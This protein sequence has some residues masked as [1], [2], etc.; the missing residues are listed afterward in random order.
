MPAL[1]TSLL[2]QYVA[3]ADAAPGGFADPAVVSRYEPIELRFDTPVDQ[4]LSPYSGAYFDQQM[5]LYREIAGRALDQETGE[6]HDDDTSVLRNAPNPTG[7]PDAA[8]VA[9]HMRSVSTMFAVARLQG[10]PAVLD[11]GAGHGLGS[12]VFAYTGCRVHAIDIDPGLGALSRERAAARDLDITRTEMN[13]DDVA[14]L[15][16]E[17]YDAAFFS[18]ALHHC[19]R[20][21]K[22]I[23]DLEPKLRP[24]GVIAFVGEPINDLWWKHWGLRLDPVSLYVARSRGWFESG[25]SHGFI[26]D[27]FERSGFQLTFLTGGFEGGEIGIAT[28]SEAKRRAILAHAAKLGLRET[29]TASG[30]GIG[31]ERFRSHTGEETRLCGRPAFR[32]VIDS[33]SALICGPYARVNVGRYEISMLVT[34]AAASSIL[35]RPGPL[36]IDISH[37]GGDRKLFRVKVRG[38]RHGK[39]QLLQYSFDVAGEIKDLEVRAFAGRRAE[40]TV[41]VPT[42]RRV[43]EAPDLVL[44]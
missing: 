3:D 2:D 12:E 38:P 21:W 31:D 34:Q 13:F 35:R 23:A 20:P 26:R 25:W 39:T 4:T 22:L 6:L 44:K 43:S 28:G 18:Q 10:R 29:H 41:S 1:H 37:D 15:P 27:C 24:D 7:I 16:N 5:A 8:Q 9:E 42:I 36:T 17:A 30:L 19:L 33:D 14:S 40:W 11:M 32:Q